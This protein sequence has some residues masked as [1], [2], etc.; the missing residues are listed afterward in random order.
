MFNLL[1]RGIEKN[2]VRNLTLFPHWAVDPYQNSSLED[3]MVSACLTT[4]LSNNNKIPAATSSLTYI[5][6]L[7]SD[8]SVVLRHGKFLTT[9]KRHLKDSLLNHS[10]YALCQPALSH[11]VLS[12]LVYKVH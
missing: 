1:T 8:P 7:L 9:S 12:A 6:T 3:Q 2:A 4:L 10:F 5:F 11:A